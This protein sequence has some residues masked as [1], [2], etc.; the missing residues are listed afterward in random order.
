MI[1]TYADWAITNTLTKPLPESMSIGPEVTVRAPGGAAISEEHVC[2]PSTTETWTPAQT[3]ERGQTGVQE[4]SPDACVG[5]LARWSVNQFFLVK[6]GAT[7]RDGELAQQRV[8]QL[9]DNQVIVDQNSLLHESLR[10]IRGKIGDGICFT[11]WTMLSSAAAF[12]LS[13]AYS[14]G[15]LAAGT[16][17]NGLNRAPLP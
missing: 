10:P 7:T 13:A 5:I 16:P 6:G 1:L 17:G 15:T 11:S 12:R 8:S 14:M 3:L 2:Q 4:A 9:N